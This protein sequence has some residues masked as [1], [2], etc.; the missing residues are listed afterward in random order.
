MINSFNHL[1]QWTMR[2]PERLRKAGWKIR[3]IGRSDNPDG[4]S[5]FSVNVRN[6]HLPRNDREV[7]ALG[8]S[9]EEAVDNAVST[10]LRT[11]PPKK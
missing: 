11:Y 5:L 2:I 9:S 7:R 4:T 6:D 10:I 1:Q 3:W 8:S